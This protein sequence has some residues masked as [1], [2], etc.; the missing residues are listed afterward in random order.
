MGASRRPPP[1]PSPKGGGSNSATPFVTAFMAGA[2]VNKD[3]RA[4]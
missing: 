3:Q 2:W 1:L 4:E